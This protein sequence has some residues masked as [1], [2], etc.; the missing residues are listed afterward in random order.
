M[1]NLITYYGD[2][3]KSYSCIIH[4]G[5]TLDESESTTTNVHVIEWL[6]TVPQHKRRL[7]IVADLFPSVG[8]RHSYDCCGH[9]YPYIGQYAGLISGDKKRWMVYQHYYQNV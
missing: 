2:N 5:I 1:E 4:S 7:E 3:D 9:W 8:C 6:G